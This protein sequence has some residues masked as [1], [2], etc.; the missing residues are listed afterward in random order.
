MFYWIKI[1][2][3]SKN[4]ENAPDLFL[5]WVTFHKYKIQ[6]GCGITVY[7]NYIP[8]AKYNLLNTFAHRSVCCTKTVEIIWK[9]FEKHH[10]HQM[11]IR[12]CKMTE[13]LAS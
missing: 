6:V 7:N 4:T 10:H 9:S 11:Q 3:N 13:I 12:Q 8:L 5:Y 1:E 2:K